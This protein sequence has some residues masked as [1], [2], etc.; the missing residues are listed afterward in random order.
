MKDEP[1]LKL[2]AHRSSGN[3]IEKSTS[4]ADKPVG[5]SNATAEPGK[6]HMG[7]T[8]TGTTSN[9]VKSKLAAVDLS[10]SNSGKG[11]GKLVVPG[12]VSKGEELVSGQRRQSES[13]P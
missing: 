10:V 2:A 9:V 6:S 3:Q 8:Q 5:N 4:S 7:R 12:P 1:P 11:A 13:R